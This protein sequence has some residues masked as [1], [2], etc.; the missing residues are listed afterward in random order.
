MLRAT[1]FRYAGPLLGEVLAL[2]QQV[3]YPRIEVS[4]VR[5]SWDTE[6][7]K[8]FLTSIARM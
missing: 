4:G 7:M 8:P 2:H 6:A 5:S 3:T 1:T